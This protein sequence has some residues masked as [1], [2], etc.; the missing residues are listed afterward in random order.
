MRDIGHQ[1]VVGG[2]WEE[3]LIAMALGIVATVLFDVVG[4]GGAEGGV[5]WSDDYDP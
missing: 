1:V 5:D 2:A 4:V 3:G